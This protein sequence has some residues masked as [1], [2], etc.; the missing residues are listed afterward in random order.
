[1]KVQ[2]F[3]FFLMAS[4]G[5]IA[6]QMRWEPSSDLPEM[7][8]FD[9]TD[10][11][12]N[13]IC[14]TLLYTPANT[15]ILTSYT[16]GFQVDCDDEA[17]A[18][19][20]NASVTMNDN[21]RQQIACESAGKILLHASGN[22]GDLQVKATRSLPLHQICVQTKVRGND[23][24]FNADEVVG[25][26]TSLDRTNELPVTERP[27]FVS[28]K[29]KRN[30]VICDGSLPNQ[31]NGG[32]GVDGI[33]NLDDDRIQIELMPNPVVNNLRIKIIM[34]APETVFNIFDSAGR[35]VL[36]GKK[37]TGVFHNLDVSDFPAGTYYASFDK[38]R[39]ELTKKFIVSR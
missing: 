21:S 19:V 2:F 26:T 15:G 7:T 36:S 9:Q 13:I 29:L 10:C 25:L 33:D 39:P 28:F 20:S 32:F 17:T 6:Q 31:P 35:L 34:E 14:Y 23:L 16:T 37:R 3:F 12:Q 24:A 22:T 38:D 5:L 30:S 18:V 4:A 8:K 11:H 1:M 27:A